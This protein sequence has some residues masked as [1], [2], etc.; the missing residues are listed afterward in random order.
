MFARFRTT[1]TRTRAI[2]ESMRRRRGRHRRDRHHEGSGVSGRRCLSRPLLGF[3]TC[4]CGVTASFCATTITRLVITVIVTAITF[5]AMVRLV[6]ATAIVLFLLP[7]LLFALLFLLSTATAILASSLFMVPGTARGTR[8]PIRLL[9]MSQDLIQA[10][11]LVAQR[12]DL[13]SQLLV[14]ASQ[15]SN[16]RLSWKGSQ[17]E[18]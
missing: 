3:I 13:P 6:A 16:V 4:G 5:F 10:I 7:L 9:V 17:L 12:P 8:L 2:R 11:V 18:F 1:R 15:L 14:L